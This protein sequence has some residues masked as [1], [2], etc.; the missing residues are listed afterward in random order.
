MTPHPTCADD[1]KKRRLCSAC[2]YW[3]PRPE[4]GSGPGLG[5]CSKRDVVTMIRC[6][7]DRFEEATPSRV[8]ARNRKIYGEIE[9]EGEDE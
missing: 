8:D 6:E 2:L 3:D 5:Y 9:E 4:D 7:C 1:P